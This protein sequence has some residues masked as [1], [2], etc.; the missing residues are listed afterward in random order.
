MVARLQIH[1]AFLHQPDFFVARD[2]ARK[3]DIVSGADVV[4]H[5]LQHGIMRSLF[6]GDLDAHARMRAVNQR[7][8]LHDLGHSLALRVAVLQPTD[9]EDEILARLIRRRVL[10]GVDAERHIERILRSDLVRDFVQLHGRAE[11]VHVG[12][13]K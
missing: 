1:A 6:A 11:D 2:R 3:L 12:V 8:R 5:L 10:M 9:A 7:R 13:T 4:R